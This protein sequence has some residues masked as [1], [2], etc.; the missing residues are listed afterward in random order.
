MSSESVLITSR[1]RKRTVK[2]C[3]DCGKTFYIQPSKASRYSRCPTCQLNGKHPPVTLICKTCGQAFVVKYHLK[4]IQHFCSAVCRWNAYTRKP[5]QIR[6]DLRRGQHIYNKVC[7][8]CGKHYKTL[9][10]KSI[11]C[12]LLCVHESQKRDNFTCAYC[13]VSFFP[14]L[15]KAHIK[16]K[17]RF[18]SRQ[19]KA[20]YFSGENHP[21][22][23]ADKCDPDDRGVGWDNLSE[24]IRQRDNHTCQRCGQQQTIRLLDVHH[25]EPYRLTRNNHPDNLIT[26]CA[27]CHKVVEEALTHSGQRLPA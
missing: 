11:Y 13:G 23:V 9:V 1:Y 25:I 8:E 14:A 18:C 27:S 16:G 5:K 26:L 12:C 6:M 17:L 4:D 10:Q 2:T 19:C 3:K 21:G 15:R 24:S 22:Y 7:L 20:K